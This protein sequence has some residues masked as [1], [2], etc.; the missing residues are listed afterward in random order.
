MNA[1]AV[2]PWVPSGVRVV[3]TVTPVANLPQQSRMARG[4]IES[5]AAVSGKMS[6]PVKRLVLALNFWPSMSDAGN[7][8]RFANA[9][10]PGTG[11]FRLRF[12]SAASEVENSRRM[13]SAPALRA[14]SLPRATS[15][16]SGAMPQLV[17]G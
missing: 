12:Y 8:G 14:L 15:R 11:Q 2:M 5:I 7:P 1:L 3:M 9:E 4:S 13:M 6:S 10:R 16:E 17:Q